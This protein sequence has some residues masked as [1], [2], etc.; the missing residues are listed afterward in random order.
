MSMKTMSMKHKGRTH[1][2]VDGGPPQSVAGQEAGGDLVTSQPTPGTLELDRRTV[3]WYVGA[4][5]AVGIPLMA[6]PAILGLESGPFILILVYVPLLGGAILSA[7]RAGPGGIRRLF[8]GV[9][10]WRIGWL[11][12]AIVIGAIPIATIGVAAMTGTYTRPSDGWLP[13]LGDHL[14]LTFVFGALIVNVFEETAWQGLVQRNLT[15]RH[16]LLKASLLTAI[17]FAAVHLPLSFVGDVTTS[18]AAVASAFLI[19]VAPVMRYVMGRTDHATGGSLL[20][21]GVM[22]A[23][24]NASGQL[25]VVEGDWQYAGGLIVVAA[26]LLL[27]DAGRRRARTA[28]RNVA[29]TDAGR[30]GDLPRATT[31]NRSQTGA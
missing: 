28:E 9:L 29:A 5:V 11:N 21:V 16:G 4:V 1:H 14:F 13:I 10:R 19:V 23:S 6:I 12:W 20:A 25:D 24:F 30:T 7:R 31:T 2:S 15:R 27:A 3:A 17:P 18:E 26:L 8:S 22:H